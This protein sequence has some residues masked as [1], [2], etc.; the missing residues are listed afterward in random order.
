MNSPRK[1]FLAIADNGM[2]LSRTSWAVSMMG[3]CLDVLSKY[4]VSIARVS[5][6]YPE[7]S[8]NIASNSFME[9]GCDEILI[10]DTDIKFSTSELRRLMT[11]EHP[12]VSGLYTKKTPGLF[13]VAAGLD[14]DASPF[15][16]DGRP[17]LRPIKRVAKGF[18]RLQR[19]VFEKTRPLRAEVEDPRGESMVE[20]RKTLPGEHSED[21]EFCDAWRSVGGQVMV[22]TSVILQHEGSIPFPILETCQKEDAA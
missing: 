16:N 22:D 21:F 13:F 20:Y 19:E 14:G 6:P 2:G 1:I 8:M 18:L 11:H 17:R 10:I 15:A 4:H 12:F 9:S 5:N 3:A 7:M